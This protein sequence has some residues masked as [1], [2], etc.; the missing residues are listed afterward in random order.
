MHHGKVVEHDT[1]A[2]IFTEAE[3]EYTRSLLAAAPS[4]L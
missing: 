3:D 1:A 2:R 4:L